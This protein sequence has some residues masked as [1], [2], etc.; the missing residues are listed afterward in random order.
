MNLLDSFLMACDAVLPIVILVVLGYILKKLKVI[1]GDFQKTCNN[2]CF[3]ILIPILLFKN[4]YDIEDLSKL[5]DYGLFILYVILFIF[6]LFV[7]GFLFVKF[8]IKDDKQKGVMHQAFYRS[9]Y[10]II[11]TALAAFISESLGLG[12]ESEIVAIAALVA[13]VSIPFF[14]MF[15]VISLTVFDK[16]NG[17]KINVKK[18][19]LNIIKNPLIIG[20]FSGLVV[21]GIRQILIACNV[22]FR[23]GDINIIYKPLSQVANMATPLALIMLGAGFTFGAVKKLKFQIIVGTIIREAL[24]PAICLIP[25]YFILKSMN[26]DIINFFPA[27]IALFAT[28]IA[29]SSVPMAQSMNQDAEL[30]GQLVVWT[31]L[32]SIVSLFVI[33]MLAGY[34]GIFVI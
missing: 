2:F 7:I 26:A 31:S 22:D 32:L 4:V 17:E 25:F 6:M 29:V 20:V 16:I 9:N 5:K 13:A 14:N 15:A 10:A 28:P 24:V 30:A 27:L 21:L 18:L 12:G 8:C 33:I 3:R 19:L 1:K 11:G 23:I 34:V